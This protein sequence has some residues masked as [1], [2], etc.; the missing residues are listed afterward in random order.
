[1]PASAKEYTAQYAEGERY[2]TYEPVVIGNVTFNF[3]ILKHF[4]G[5][6]DLNIWFTPNDKTRQNV[7]EL[8]TVF[9]FNATT[10]KL[11]IFNQE[12]LEDDIFFQNRMMLNFEG[13][14]RHICNDGST[15]CHADYTWLDQDHKSETNDDHRHTL[16]IGQVH[17]ITL[18]CWDWFCTRPD[19]S[20]FRERSSDVL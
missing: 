3:K 4:L 10:K 9:V 6:K 16:G 7:V 17:E 5:G 19:G 2:I 14:Y 1:M 18:S 11:T 8:N 15:L 20:T 12:V 13:E